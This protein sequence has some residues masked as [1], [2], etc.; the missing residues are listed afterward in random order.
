[1]KPHRHTHMQTTRSWVSKCSAR[2]KVHRLAGKGKERLGGK[3]E[4]VCCHLSSVEEGDSEWRL[5]SQCPRL[6]MYSLVAANFYTV[7]LDQL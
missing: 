4:Y 2:H 3:N 1:M 6:T 7:A 5:S